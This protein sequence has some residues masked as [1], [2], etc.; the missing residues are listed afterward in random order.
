MEVGARTVDPSNEPGILGVMNAVMCAAFDVPS[1]AEQV[2][3]FAASQPDGLAVV[4][5]DGA[6]VGTGAAIAY[7]DA[8]FGWIGLIGTRPDMG[9]RGIGTIVTDHL[10]E[11]LSSHG[12]ASVLDAS[13]KGRPVYERLGF[14]DHGP[15]QVMMRRAA[16]ITPAPIAPAPIVTTTT[17]QVIA[18]APADLADLIAYDAASFGARR[19]RIVPRVVTAHDTVV[20]RRDGAVVGYAVRRPSILGPVVADDDEVLLALLHAVLDA[21][22]DVRIDVPWESRHV[23]TLVA[24]GFETV[25][26]LRNMRLG[27]GSLP[28]KRD[29]IAGQLTLGFG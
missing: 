14:V 23:G 19:D 20:A 7:D 21:R 15:T 27:I 28:G 22:T 16:P 26:E 10:V 11:V 29:R 6:V 24:A 18:V 3:W 13:A 1:F 8:G 5:I 2:G 9:R 25:R 4:E 12:C 17:A